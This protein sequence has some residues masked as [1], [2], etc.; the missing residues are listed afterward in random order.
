MSSTTS[1][2]TPDLKWAIRTA[3]ISLVFGLLLAF[4]F[5]FGMA[6]AFIAYG[7]FTGTVHGAPVFSSVLSCLPPL[8]LAW[9]IPQQVRAMAAGSPGSF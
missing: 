4:Q 3:I 8:G 9:L 6:F 7:T 2:P 1:L 5:A